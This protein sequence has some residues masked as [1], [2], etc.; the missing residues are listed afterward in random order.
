MPL[1]KTSR[2]S[3]VKTGSQDFRFIR[4]PSTWK[5]K[6]RPNQGLDTRI[7]KIRASAAAERMRS[8]YLE[9]AREELVVIED[10]LNRAKGSE[11]P[12]RA[13]ALATIRKRVFEMKNE[14]G[15]LGYPLMTRI[16]ASL[17]DYIEEIG[18]I[19]PAQLDAVS[20]HVDALRIVVT[21]NIVGEGDDTAK[22]VLNGID[23]LVS[24]T[25]HR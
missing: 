23:R 8:E 20:I 21:R 18:E 22:E 14:A 25:L 10:A 24:K 17:C 11:A 3:A 1:A 5:R 2:F 19:G 16:G 7:I 6:V 9:H 12:Q 15:C 4:P 13:G